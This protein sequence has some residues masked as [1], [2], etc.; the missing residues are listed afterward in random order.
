MKNSNEKLKTRLDSEI[1]MKGEFEVNLMQVEQKYVTEKAAFDNLKLQFDSQK[2]VMLK[3][4]EN[5]SKQNNLYEDELKRIN[6]LRTK[7]LKDKV[8]EISELKK[9][10]NE[11]NDELAKIEN[12][13]LG[14]G[15]E[16]PELKEGGASSLLNHVEQINKMLEER[17][18]M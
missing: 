14:K 2:A 8:N 15:G 17:N 3:E 12:E 11:K 1:L 4:S 6:E 18:L 13:L 10:L 5:L 16:V 7:E 9:L